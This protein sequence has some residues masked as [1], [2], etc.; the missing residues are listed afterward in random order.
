MKIT[1]EMAEELNKELAVRGYPFRY[2]YDE[3]MASNLHM[4]MTLPSMKGV[5]SF[6]INPTREYLDWLTLWFKIRGIEISW[7][8]TASIMWSS[9]GWDDEDRK[10]KK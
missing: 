5:H 7:N 6:I 3:N 9:S 8:N 4:E 10:E 2:D 1:K